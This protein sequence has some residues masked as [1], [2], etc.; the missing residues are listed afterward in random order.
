MSLGKSWQNNVVKRRLVEKCAVHKSAQRNA[1]ACLKSLPL[2]VLI[3]STVYVKYMKDENT[4]Q[5]ISCM[6]MYVGGEEILSN[7]TDLDM[8]IKVE[9]DRQTFA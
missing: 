9:S 6:S 8:L 7:P 5:Y 3:M 2:F 4:A 1:H